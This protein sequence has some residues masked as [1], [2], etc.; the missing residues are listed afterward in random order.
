MLKEETR[1]SFFIFHKFRELLKYP[2]GNSDEASLV[3]SGR[4]PPTWPPIA[5][6]PSFSS[7]IFFLAWHYALATR[8]L[9]SGALLKTA[10]RIRIIDNF[11]GELLRLNDIYFTRPEILLN[12]ILLAKIPAVESFYSF[13][14]VAVER[15]MV[16]EL[17]ECI[18]PSGNKYVSNV[19]EGR[20]RFIYVQILCM[21]PL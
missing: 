5:I 15:W 14:Y 12:R 2:P 21:C 16:G 19:V 13:F 18:F 10:N 8:H 4:S 17:K 3:G 20:S 9:K 6:L 11:Y 7:F 1:L